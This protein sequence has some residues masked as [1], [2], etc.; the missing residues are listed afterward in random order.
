M[1]NY[2]E[3]REVQHFT[4]SIVVENFVVVLIVVVFVV[5][6]VQFGIINPKDKRE[7]ITI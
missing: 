4:V 1:T 6:I 7:I 2:I 3:G 5:L